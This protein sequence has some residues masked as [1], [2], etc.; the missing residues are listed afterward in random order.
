VRADPEDGHERGI[1]LEN[2]RS[3]D[4]LGSG[5]VPV[6]ATSW[7]A[8]LRA[9]NLGRRRRMAMADLRALLESLGYAEVRTHLQSGN[10]LFEATEKR[11][12]PLEHRI[13]SRIKADLGLA[14]EVFVRSATQLAR[15]VDENP[16]VARGIDPKHL[17]ATFLS[18]PPPRR[19]VNR[20]DREEYAPDEFELGER[21]IYGHLPNG[22]MGSRLPDWEELL[23]LSATSRSWNTVS[24]L[25][26]LANRAA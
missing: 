5:T 2:R 3:F 9:I 21:V 23:G 7:V 19:I 26:T 17:Q 25:S 16:F 24:R 1:R 18:A 4:V 8:L 11:P 6:T 20:I 13:A 22:F 14:V 12:G 15:V 10:A